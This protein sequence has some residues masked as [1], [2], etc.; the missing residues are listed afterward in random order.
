MFKLNFKDWFGIITICL[1]P[2]VGFSAWA[3][4]LSTKQL[5]LEQ[6]LGVIKNDVDSLTKSGTEIDRLQIIEL[7]V[8]SQRVK[9]LEE[10]WVK[11]DGKLDFLI[12]RTKKN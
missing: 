12:E 3:I 7:A 1:T 4:T 11:I 2:A 6:T 5:V 10:K 9:S 8:M